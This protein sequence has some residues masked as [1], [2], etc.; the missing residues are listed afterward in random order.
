MSLNTDIE[1]F[2]PEKVMFRFSIEILLTQ[3]TKK[4]GRGTLLCST[5][6]LVSKRIMD[7]REGRRE[8]GGETEGGRE[9]LSRFLS[10]V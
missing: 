4:L 3:S 9:G 1:M 8:G 10:K 6:I 5:K 2:L 7:K